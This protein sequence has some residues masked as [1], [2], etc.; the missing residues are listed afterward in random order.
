MLMGPDGR[1]WTLR[2]FLDLIY[3]RTGR[4]PRPGEYLARSVG[5]A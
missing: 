3:A 5:S 4:K 2:R 1:P